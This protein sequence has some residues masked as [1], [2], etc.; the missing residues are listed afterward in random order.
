[1]FDICGCSVALSDADE[2]V[3][4]RAKHVVRGREGYGLVDAIDFVAFNYLRMGT[5]N[6]ISPSSE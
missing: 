6:D 4:S 3:T 1:M 5:R 2:E